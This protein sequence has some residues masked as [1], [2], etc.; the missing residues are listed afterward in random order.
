MLSGMI[1][2]GRGLDQEKE[3]SLRTLEIIEK[4]MSVYEIS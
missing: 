3:T 4:D 2:I 1:L